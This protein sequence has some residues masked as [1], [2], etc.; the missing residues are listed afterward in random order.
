MAEISKWEVIWSKNKPLIIFRSIKRF[1]IMKVNIE[2]EIILTAPIK[3]KNHQEIYQK[4][5]KTLCE[6]LDLDGMACDQ[7]RALYNEFYREK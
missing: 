7:I 6:K 3:G 2:D 5:R 4:I 1:R